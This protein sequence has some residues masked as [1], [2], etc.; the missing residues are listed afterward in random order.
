MSEQEIIQE[1]R[2]LSQKVDRLSFFLESM[3]GEQ[4]SKKPPRASKP[5]AAPPTP[6]EVL[7]HQTRFGELYEQWLSGDEIGVQ[8]RLD[9]IEVEELR[10]FADSNNL[11]VTSKMSKERV[12]QLLGARF[13]EKKQLHQVR[14]AVAKSG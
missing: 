10:R 8:E 4:Q 5:K 7:Q 1:L 6:E 12:L 3:R 2:A 13:R 9:K 11:N 14:P